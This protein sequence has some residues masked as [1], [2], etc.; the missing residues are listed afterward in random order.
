[1]RNVF[2]YGLML[3]WSYIFQVNVITARR[4]KNVLPKVLCDFEDIALT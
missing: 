3:S 2:Q 4:L 1:M